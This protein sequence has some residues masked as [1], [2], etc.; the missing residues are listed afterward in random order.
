MTKSRIFTS[1]SMIAIATVLGGTTFVPNMA[2]ADSILT[3]TIASANGEKMGGVTV[4]AKADGATITTSVYTDDSG[5]YYF[6]PLADG[7]YRVWAQALTFQTAKGNVALNK[8]SHQDF[9]LQPMKTQEDWVRQLP[10]DEFLAALPED[11]AED[12]RMKVQVRKNCT[13]CHTASYP[14][15]HRFDEEGWSRILDLM[16]HVNVLGTYQGANHKATPNIEFHQKQLAAYLARARGPGETSMKFKLRPRPTGEAARV[17]YKEYDFPMENGHSPSN[18]GSDWSLGTP[19]GMNHMNGV[20]DAQAD[21]DGNIWFTY[22][23]P[24]FDTT[25][26]KI[27]AKTGATKSIK[28]ED[29]KGFATGSHGMTRDENGYLWFNTRSNVQRGLGGLGK[30]DPKAEKVTVYLPPK[31]TT[32]TAGTLD[33][34]LNGS[35][36]VTSPDG[37]FRF[38]I[39]KEAFTEYKSI[40]YKNEQ[41][42]ATVYGLAADRVGNGWWLLMQQDLIDYG[43]R[44]TGKVGEF[45]LPPDKSAMDS[46]SPEQRKMYETFIPPDFNTPF[47]WAQAPRRMGADKKG[48]VVWIGNSFGGNLA[49]VNIFTKETTLVPLPNPA[50]QQPYEVAVDKDHNA[51]TNLWSTDVI[52]KYDPSTS[53]WT[54]FDLPNRGTETRY[55]SL[56]EREGQPMQV[57]IPYSRTRKVAVMTVRS[58]A[59]LAAL[60]A[61]AGR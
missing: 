33:A 36:W 35:V 30:V 34:D 51:W 57:I 23:H 59:D 27:D 52:A 48:D 47:A 22:A 28:L 4:S 16:K 53:K 12:A 55:I 8:T 49:K 24:G 37:A 14:L 25:V 43:D 31:S 19:S 39:A 46:L 26:A 20:H 45:K 32:G 50:S 5:N 56:L 44:N 18:D 3:G 54:L 2:Y 42:T 21:L 15:Q 60:K 41:G 17:V 61:Q 1:A 40:T 9:V 13:G 6:P 29:V 38:D 58:E 10:G 7:E 11:T